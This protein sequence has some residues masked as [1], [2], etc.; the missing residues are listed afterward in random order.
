MIFVTLIVTQW[1]SAKNCRSPTESAF[2]LGIF[3][4]RLLWIVYI[5]DVILVGIL[6][7]FPPLTVLFDLTNVEFWEWVLVFSIA[8]VVFIVEEARK[9]IAK[10]STR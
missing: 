8:S 10:R 2:S 3:R 1:F 7:I 9:K 6:F 4:N 5:I